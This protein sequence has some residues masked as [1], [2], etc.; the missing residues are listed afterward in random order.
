[1]VQNTQHIFKERRGAGAGRAVG[2]ENVDSWARD[3]SDVSLHITIMVL[4][5]KE[6]QRQRE[7]GRSHSVIG[8]I[9]ILG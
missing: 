2:R 9:L 7:P 5:E 8:E 4:G 3:L 6:R 1:M